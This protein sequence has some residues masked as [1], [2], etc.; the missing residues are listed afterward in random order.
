[1]SS[2]I[3]INFF[4]NKAQENLENI[5]VFIPQ[6]NQTGFF[7]QNDLIVT[8]IPN[9]I[10]LEEYSNVVVKKDEKN[11][12]CN[13]ELIEKEYCCVFLSFPNK[14]DKQVLKL[15]PK[16]SEIKPST[17]AL[18]AYYNGEDEIDSSIAKITGIRS[19]NKAFDKRQYIKSYSNSIY[20]NVVG[21]P[22]WGMETNS[23]IGIACEIE[24]SMISNGIANLLVLP[25]TVLN[26]S[27]FSINERFNQSFEFDSTSVSSDDLS[28]IF[29][30]SKV[31]YEEA[32]PYQTT[33]ASPET[34]KQQLSILN[35]SRDKALKRWHTTRSDC[36]RFIDEK[37]SGVTHRIGLTCVLP[38]T[39]DA[40]YKYK[41]GEKREFE[42]METDISTSSNNTTDYFCFQSFIYAGKNLRNVYSI[43]KKSIITHVLNL[44]N[45]SEDIYCIA[46][47]G[48]NA[49]KRI[50]QLFENGKD[51]GFSLDNRPFIEWHFTNA[52]LFN[53]KNNFMNTNRIVQQ[54]E[55]QI[56]ENRKQQFSC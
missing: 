40:Y 50:S 12:T 23:V 36:L 15:C 48:T 43:L 24:H 45:S 49:G 31:A 38:L 18:L 30:M 56:N 42:I 25:S 21:A 8:I 27:L 32:N 47:I 4:D 29:V 28:D 53:L 5:L 6:W 14:L 11:Y 22:V 26:E 2:G 54:Q 37:S 52:E 51:V 33:F 17:N 19:V 20:N 16:V 3:E 7:I 46:E 34:I 35:N 1:M 9:N 10:E 39:K 13:I 55:A 41:N 44:S